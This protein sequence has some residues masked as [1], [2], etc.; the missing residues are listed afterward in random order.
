MYLESGDFE[1]PIGTLINEYKEAHPVYH[2]SGEGKCTLTVNKNIIT[3][4]VG[5]NLTIDTDRMIAYRKD[6]TLNNAD[7]AGDYE[8]M[9]LPPGKNTITA[10]NGFTVTVQPKWRRL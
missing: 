8:G 9:W 7:V 10:T 1:I 2:I 4:N 6:G 5:Q 3:C